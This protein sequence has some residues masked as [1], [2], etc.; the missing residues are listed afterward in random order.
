MIKTLQEKVDE[1]ALEKA[2]QQYLFDHLWLLDPSWERAEGTAV[3]EKRVTAMFAEVTAG[4]TDEEK[5]GR[6]DIAYRKAAG[7]HV[8]IE[9][10]RPERIVGRSEMLDQAE[11][12]LSGMLRLLEAQGTPHEPIEIVFVLGANPREWSNPDGK[13]RVREALKTSRAR[14]VFYDELLTNADQAYGDYLAAHVK[15]DKLWEVF[16]AIDDFAPP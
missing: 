5:R 1:N 10:K 15:L 2:I 14:V 11:K 8:I 3:M 16:A 12:Y 4:L 6:L 13:N 9:L 7:E